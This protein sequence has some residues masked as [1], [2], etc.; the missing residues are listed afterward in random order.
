MKHNKIKLLLV[1]DYSTPV[2]TG[3]YGSYKRAFESLNVNTV[4]YYF[5]V[6]LKFVRFAKFAYITL[7]LL[8][9][10]E[11]KRF[12]H[13][14]TQNSITH[15]LV[16]KGSYLLPETIEKIKN[17][18]ITI[19]NYNPDN[20]FNKVKSSS[21][22]IIKN[23]INYY[24][25]YFIW[26]KYLVDLINTNFQTKAFYL[27][28]AVDDTL[29][30]LNIEFNS[31]NYKYP[32]SFIG[33]AD[34]ERTKQINTLISKYPQLNAQLFLFGDGWN[35]NKTLNTNY[36]LHGADYF[37]TIYQ[38]RINL[39]ILRKQNKNAHNMRT[40]EIPACGGFMLHEYSNEAA[41]LFEP[42]KEAIYFSNNT[43]CIDK[44]Q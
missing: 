7:K 17:K 6:N 15:I 18:G 14:V 24:D 43:E 26:S 32:V 22:A 16:F 2:Y 21:N 36:Q 12:I 41:E 33:N 8:V 44:I 37:Q 11:Q 38:S 10:H 31:C 34:K 29:I 20:P 4:D 27:P 9:Q 23:A 40:F 13:F 42:D 5:N 1:G 30:K 19:A 35:K 3:I 25:Y 28:F 39:N